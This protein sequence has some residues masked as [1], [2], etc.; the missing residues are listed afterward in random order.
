MIGGQMVKNEGC[1][2]A[3]FI[4][5]AMNFE[6]SADLIDKLS[7]MSQQL[8]HRIPRFSSGLFSFDLVLF[9]SVSFTQFLISYLKI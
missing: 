9:H 3:K 6:A 5:K 7:K 8:I 1:N 2:T 4:H